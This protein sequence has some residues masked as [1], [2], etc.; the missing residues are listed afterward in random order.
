MSNTSPSEDGASTASSKSVSLEKIDCPYCTWQAQ[1]RYLFN[2][3]AKHHPSDIYTAIG[4]SKKVEKDWKDKKLLELHQSWIQYDKDDTLKEY[5][6]GRDVTVHGCFGCLKSFQTEERGSLHVS[7]SPKC[8]KEHARQV[9]SYLQEIKESEEKNKGK[10][11]LYE[12]SDHE[13]DLG[14]ER[15]RRWH[16]RIVNYDLPILKQVPVNNGF[17][18]SDKWMHFD[19]FEAS[20]YKTKQQKLDAYCLHSSFIHSMNI[21][22]SRRLYMEYKFPNPFGFVDTF[23]LEGLKPVG[24]VY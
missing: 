2:H 5:P 9:K 22:L 15:L 17:Q 11:W 19:L 18:L 13:I 7:K 23:H 4:T 20:E 14:I 24:S 10:E 6:I 8:H 21:M 16:Y 12:L 3:I 1:S